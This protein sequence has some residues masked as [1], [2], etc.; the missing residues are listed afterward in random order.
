MRNLPATLL[1]LAAL[2]AYGSL[3]DIS[4]VNVL[5]AAPGSLLPG[6][7]LSDSTIFGF[8]EQQGL[9]LSSALNVGIASPG[10]Y[11]C[12]AS[13]PGG[14]V[15]A[16][17]DVNSYMLYASPATDSTG[18]NYRDF[19]GTV[20]FSPGETVV[21]II[22][23]YKNIAATDILLGAPG[24]L[25]PPV[26]D[27]LGGLENGDTVILG[28]NGHS[29]YVN[30]HVDA[31]VQGIDMIRILTDDVP[32]PADLTL[33]GSG[34]LALGFYKRRRFFGRTNQPQI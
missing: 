7:L 8:S 10:T 31:N 21:G 25:Y 1:V 27:Q 26:S 23:G 4:G 28:A 33:L 30:F 14:T 12:C 34:L 5:P 17:L 19:T 3:L 15:A 9:V 22:V 24:S 13:V 2:P 16:G 6:A 18:L 11:V 32:E 29:V 20:T